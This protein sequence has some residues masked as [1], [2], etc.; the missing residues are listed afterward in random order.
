MSNGI[1]D[2]YASGGMS[3]MTPETIPNAIVDPETGMIFPATNVGVPD[4]YA[5]GGMSV[6]TPET[7]PGGMIDPETVMVFVPTI[8]QAGV[9]TA[10]LVPAA[11]AALG[12]AIPYVASRVPTIASHIICLVVGI[13]LYFVVKAINK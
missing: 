8:A 9:P 12:K 2:E 7:V 3:L 11:A 6:V 5:S 13:L 4:E 10:A 1:P